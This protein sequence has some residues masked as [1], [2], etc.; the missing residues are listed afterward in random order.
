M[1][2]RFK[3]IFIFS[4]VILAALTAAT[5]AMGYAGHLDGVLSGGLLGMA[6]FLGWP[7][8]YKRLMA[9]D[10]GAGRM[11]ILALMKFVLLFGLTAL[12]VF[13]AKVSLFGFAA[14]FANV[15]LAIGLEGVFG[16]SGKEK[17]P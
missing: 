9:D 1:E 10:A 5:L 11:L 8:A 2:R 12:L 6:S 7:L 14:G 16:G 17:Q 3:L 15:P 4:V 13:V